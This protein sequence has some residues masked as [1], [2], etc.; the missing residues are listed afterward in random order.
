M[1]IGLQ[2]L[3]RIRQ[4]GCLL[5]PAVRV[6]IPRAA[7]YRILLRSAMTAWSDA[8]L[9]AYYHALRRPLG[10]VAAHGAKT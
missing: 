7:V 10:D 5:D 3:Q 2:T 8:G 6:R 1:L 9:G 4:A